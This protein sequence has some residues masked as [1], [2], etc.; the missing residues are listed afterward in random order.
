MNVVA[1]VQ[2][3]LTSSR[4]PGK[5]LKNISSYTVLELIYL[6]L[7]RSKLISKIIFAIPDNIENEPL[8]NYLQNNLRVNIVSASEH[9]VLSRFVKASEEF[10]AE[11]YIRI[12]SD[13]PF[14]CPEIIDEV[15]DISFKENLDYISNIDPL[16]FPDGVDC[17]VFTRKTL[18][19]LDA[20]IE[21]ITLREHVTLGLRKLT[22]EAKRLTG[23]VVSNYIPERENTSWM[24]ITL[25]TIDD[26][27]N[28]LKLSSNIEDLTT[29]PLEKIEEI[30]KKL[31][32]KV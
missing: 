7:K 17:E 26:Y 16:L 10:L 4:F 14:I 31:F 18:K 32:F 30:Y 20:N 21:D 28:L 29:V 27:L 15:V 19:W 9:D 8:A 1:I 12:T 24:R 6:R 2:A 5:V 13:C 22:A 23:L 25:D 11:K 3:R